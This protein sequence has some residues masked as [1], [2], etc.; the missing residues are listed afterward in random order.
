MAKRLSRNPLGATS[1]RVGRFTTLLPALVLVLLAFA[2]PFGYTIWSSFHSD[3]LRPKFVGLANYLAIFEDPVLQKSVLNT[4]IWVVGGLLLPVLLGLGLA[5]LTNSSLMG[6]ITRIVV[7]IP[8]ALSGTAVAVVGSAMLR[9]DGALNSV[10]DLL[11]LGAWQHAWLTEWPV[12]TFAMVVFSAWQAT[13]AAVL[14]F[15][16]GLQGIPR[17]TMEASS[18]DGA[19]GL[20]QFWWIVLPQLRPVTVVVVG[21]TIANSLKGFDYIQVLTHGGPA[22][23]TETLALSAYRTMFLL[24]QPNLGSA[25]SVLLTIV[26]VLSAWMYLRNQRLGRLT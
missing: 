13:G 6:Q 9:Q 4:A 26:V 15:M 22:R 20:K 2:V 5:V 1:D 25:I 24:K 12:N 14:L 3:G 19:S 18:I 7:I 23:S 8:F 16:V 10:L 17:E 21:T 11:G